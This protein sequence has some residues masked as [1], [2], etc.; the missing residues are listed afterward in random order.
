MDP[1]VGASTCAII[2]HW[3]RG[4]NGT[5]KLKPKNKDINI[6]FRVPLFVLSTNSHL[7]VSKSEVPKISTI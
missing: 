6:N 2:S 4:T 1:V 3:C 5:L 7:I